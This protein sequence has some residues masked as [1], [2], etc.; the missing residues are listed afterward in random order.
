MFHQVLT[1]TNLDKTFTYISKKDLPIGS[2]IQIPFGP[3][4]QKIHGIIVQNNINFQVSFVCKELIEMENL[5]PF[6]AQMIS[7]SQK[8][9]NYNLIP[10]GS[11]LK[12]FFSIKLNP[13]PQLQTKI[14]N[15]KNQEQENFEFTSQNLNQLQQK[16]AEEIAQIWQKNPQKTI[17]LHGETGSGKTEIYFHL[18]EQVL[19]RD[20][21][22]QILILIPEIALTFELLTRIEKKFGTAPLIWN[23]EVKNRQE[24]WLQVHFG[25]VQIIV[26]A[27]SALFLPFCNLQLIVIDEEHD[28]SFKQNQNGI[29][30]ARDMAVLY[31]HIL[32][33]PTLL[34]SAT[35]SLESWHNAQNNKYSRIELKKEQNSNVEIAVVTMKTWNN[36]FSDQLIAQINEKL[37]KNEQ[38]LL[39]M[40]RKGYANLFFCDQCGHRF[41]CANCSV[42]LTRH[43][44]KNDQLICR[45]CGFSIPTPKKCSNCNNEKLSNKVPGIEQIFLQAREIFPEARIKTIS[46]DSKVDKILQDIKN[47][48]IDIVIGTQII[49]KG[50]NF[51]FLS[52]VAIL[53]LDFHLLGG[54]LR[55]LEK[56]WQIIKQVAGRVGRFEIDGKVLLQTRNPNSQLIKV[57]Q[58]ANDD[59]FYNFEMEQRQIS[60]MPPFSKLIHICVSHSNEQ[61]AYIL[62]K[63][64]ANSLPQNKFE[65]LGPTSSL[66]SKLSGQFRQSILLKTAQKNPN[67]KILQELAQKI[68]S[69]HIKIDIDPLDFC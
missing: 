33:I 69:K 23:S 59:F 6:S 15:I 35:P 1:T 50:H 57:L 12:M 53:D 67:L 18:I 22:A 54:D 37:A 60:H 14:S 42:L 13:T 55:A 29:Y 10:W 38:I 17:L 26:G 11:V 47:R 16:A 32:Q 36:F 39:F 64:F 51:P 7:F 34:S 63:N 27:R 62:A 61:K 46:S 66:L 44:G 3:K 43:I 49:A 65:I 28:P 8:L 30:N 52:L 56:S 58:S 68:A 20:Q 2:I 25:K 41:E 5:Q 9:A 31:S 48:E 24:K 19:T 40:N 4:N 45:H 21:Q